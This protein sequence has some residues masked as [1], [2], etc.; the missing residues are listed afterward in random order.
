MAT[1]FPNQRN[2]EEE[3]EV[4]T[5][6]DNTWKWVAIGSIC[7]LVVIII[8]GILVFYFGFKEEE[9]WGGMTKEYMGQV[10]GAQNILDGFGVKLS[11]LSQERSNCYNNVLLANYPITPCP[12]PEKP[13]SSSTYG[14]Y[15]PFGFGFPPYQN[16]TKK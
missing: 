10:K 2:Q 11:K 6:S 14:G 16:P 12:A 1:S 7:V 5:S 3:D 4:K 9:A 13:S 8:I 15:R